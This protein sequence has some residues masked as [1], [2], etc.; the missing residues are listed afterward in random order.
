MPERIYHY[1]GIESLALILKTRKLRF[2]R[3]DRV[4]DVQEAQEHAG[5]NFGKYFFVSCWTQQAEESIPQWSM[6]SAGMRG[7]RIEL[8]AYPFSDEPLRS[9]PGWSGVEW[10]GE[11]RGPVPFEFLWGESYFVVPMFLTPDQFAG[12]VEYVGD[13]SSEYSRAIQRTIH[14]GG[15]VILKVDGLPSLPRKKSNDWEFQREYRFSLFVM[16][17]LPVPEGGSARFFERVGQHMSNSF[18]R[19]IDP[20]I[21]FIDVPLAPDAFDHLVVRTAPLA[22]PGGIA[23]VEA[24]LAQYAPRAR[25]EPSALTGNIRQRSQ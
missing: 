24:L 2:T 16:P 1:T 8:P 14:A 6:Y 15:N 19:N 7:V 21:N 9:K 22:S 13:V 5:I 18:I 4:D 17:S 3:L 10:S 25:L 11:I 20:G 23:C 12:A